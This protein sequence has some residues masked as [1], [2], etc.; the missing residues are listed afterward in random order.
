MQEDELRFKQALE[1]TTT[2]FGRQIK[3]IRNSL[4][5]KG[6]SAII[7]VYVNPVQVMLSVLQPDSVLHSIS[8][9][10]ESMIL[11][12]YLDPYLEV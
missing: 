1:Q 11:A 12:S 9:R 10:Q 6:Q 4:D 2:S 5:E 7:M 3:S 8:F